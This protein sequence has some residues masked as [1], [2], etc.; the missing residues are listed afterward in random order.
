MVAT[1]VKALGIPSDQKNT[2]QEAI[3]EE[4][5]AAIRSSRETLELGPGNDTDTEH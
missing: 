4:A 3:I 5:A 2:A 1:T